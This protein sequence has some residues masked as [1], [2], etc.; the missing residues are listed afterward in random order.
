M[1]RRTTPTRERP[2]IAGQLRDAI[3][4]SGLSDYALGRRS[5]VAPIVIGRFLRGVR[6]LNLDTADRLA[7]ALGFKRVEFA[8]TRRAAPDRPPPPPPE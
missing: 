7:A 4:Q 1:G 3:R 2:T 6:G 5:G 8:R